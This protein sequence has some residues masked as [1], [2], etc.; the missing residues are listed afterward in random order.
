M[1][2]CCK[3]FKNSQQKLLLN[4]YLALRYKEALNKIALSKQHLSIPGI[5]FKNLRVTRK[6]VVRLTGFFVVEGRK[7]VR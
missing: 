2:A 3:I 4:L 6:L 5:K 7:L 1:I